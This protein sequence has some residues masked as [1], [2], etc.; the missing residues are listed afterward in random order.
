MPDIKI[1]KFSHDTDRTVIRAVMNPDEPQ[2]RHEVGAPRMDSEGVPMLDAD[3]S[4]ILMT[5]DDLVIQ[6]GETGDT[7]ESQAVGA[8]L[9]YNCRVNWD[10]R[11]YI[12]DDISRS[13][14]QRHVGSHRVANDAGELVRKSDDVFIQEMREY[15]QREEDA[16]LVTESPLVGQDITV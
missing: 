15:M 5:G 1:I 8:T 4:P 9:C 16:K 12:W 7:E 14:T 2:W 3:G 10:I 11:E 13:D 6:S